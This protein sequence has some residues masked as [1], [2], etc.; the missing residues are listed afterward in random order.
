MQKNQSLA[1]SDLFTSKMFLK[2]LEEYLETLS[3]LDSRE[4]LKKHIREDFIGLSNYYIAIGNQEFERVDDSLNIDEV[5]LLHFAFPETFKDVFLLHRDVILQLQIAVAKELEGNTD[6]AS[7]KNHLD[8]SIKMLIEAT[9]YSIN[10]VNE[11]R[12][13]IYNSEKGNK[14]LLNSIKHKDNAWP[15]YKKQF[16]DIAIQIK[17]INESHSS[18]NRTIK[19]LKSINLHTIDTV[20]VNTNASQTII[21]RLGETIK[22]INKMESTN[23]ITKLITWIDCNIIESSNDQEQSDFTKILEEKVKTL[24]ATNIPVDTENGILLARQIDFNK[25]VKKWFDFEIIPLF[26][27]LWEQIKTMETF[28]NHSLLNLKS[29][30]LVEKSNDTLDALPSQLQTLKSVHQTL[31]KSDEVLHKIAKE[32]VSKIEQKLQASQIYS[33]KE[34]LE[35]SIQSSLYQFANNQGNIFTNAKNKITKK[36]T[37]I[38]SKYENGALFSNLSKVDQSISCISHRMFKEVNAH[39]DT[40]FLNKNFIGDLFLIP[41]KL[42]KFAFAK[43]KTD[44]DNGFNKAVIINGAPLSGTSTF[45][46]T[47]AQEYFKKNTV[48]LTV[49]TVIPFE[50]RKIQT[51]RNLNDALKDIKKNLSG[52]KPLLVID[53][54]E[55][56][57]D[58]KQ[59]LLENTRALLRFIES[60]SDNVMVVVSISRQMQK[61][62]DRRIRF[63][64]G[65]ST[66]ITLDKASFEEIYK[67]FLMRHGASHKI[68][69]SEKKEI[70]S[71]KRI[72]SN[73]LKLA[74]DCQYNIGEVLQSWTYGTTII[75]NNQVIYEYK[76]LSFK[77]FFIAEELIIL[78]FVFL[79]KETNELR[80]ITYFGTQ[81]ET[82]YK[83]SLK[84][85]INLKVLLRNQQAK[86]YINPVVINDIKDI[87]IYRGT[88]S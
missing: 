51:T 36:I 58:E 86:L 16:K 14:K 62:L 63:T 23:D 32:I 59:S 53:T 43:A 56:W 18:V 87:L 7:A 64:D 65:F 54:L 24:T 76:R 11:E 15:I 55:L 40:L 41:R 75:E 10:H 26:I 33:N 67:G 72:E 60:E 28:F 13:A 3:T 69:V 34:F 6:G 81:F 9:Q 74:R 71:N 12:R 44:W 31:T 68:L 70:L 30:L 45:L 50:G 1:V 22:S 79:N 80:L 73:L 52:S 35:V 85:M 17:E 48:F 21:K 19:S 82:K 61:Q 77:D 25:A 4:G 8:H 39:Y 46:Q 88:L 47:V 38:N 29:S 84:R 49:D 57:Q 42:Q 2:Q 37:S 20:F 27:D 66:T 78:K 83:S 5:Y